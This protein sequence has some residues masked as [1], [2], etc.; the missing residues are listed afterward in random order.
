ML[1]S[2]CFDVCT[3]RVKACIPGALRESELKEPHIWGFTV[4]FE[5]TVF[6]QVAEYPSSSMQAPGSRAY[7]QQTEIP[8]SVQ[9]CVSLVFL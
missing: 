3:R 8:M 1:T 6:C 9:I 7:T 2:M 5:G 4:G